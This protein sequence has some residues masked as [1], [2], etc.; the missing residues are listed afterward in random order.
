MSRFVRLLT[1]S[2]VL[3]GLAGGCNSHK[4]VTPTSFTPPPKSGPV[5]AP[6]GG[7]RGPGGQA[8]VSVPSAQ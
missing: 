1:V 6:A 4:D 3:A 5:G 2:V 8:P 7:A